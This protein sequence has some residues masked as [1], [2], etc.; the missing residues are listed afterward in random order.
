MPQMIRRFTELL[1]GST[2]A[3][4]E[5][6]LT[7]EE[8]IRQLSKVTRR[9]AFLTLFREAAVGEVS[10]DRVSLSRHKPTFSNAFKPCFIGQFGIQQGRVVLSGRFTMMLFVKVFMTCWFG[11]CILWTCG[12][13]L[14]VLRSPLSPTFLPLG[15]LLMLG[16]GI[17][18]VSFSKR[19][20]SGDNEYLSSVIRGALSSDA[21]GKPRPRRV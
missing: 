3:E 9:S 6:V 17:G 18:F 21:G 12:A 1:Y 8:S 2:P 10:E 15:G 13:T 11:F 7:L 14:A 4:F 5:S 16:L 20:S 19:L